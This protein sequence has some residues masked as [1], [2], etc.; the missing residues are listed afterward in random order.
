MDRIHLAQ[1]GGQ[2][3]ALVNKEMTFRFHKMVGNSSAAE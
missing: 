3:Q 1:D 2:W